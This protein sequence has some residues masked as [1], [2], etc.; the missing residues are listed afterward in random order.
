[1]CWQ[2]VIYEWFRGLSHRREQQFECCCCEFFQLVFLGGEL[3]DGVSLTERQGH[4]WLI[5]VNTFF[6]HIHYIGND[7]YQY[8][9]HCACE[10][11]SVIV[12]FN[13]LMWS[14]L[15]HVPD[16]VAVG[17]KPVYVANTYP[18]AVTPTRPMATAIKLI[19]TTP[20]STANAV[21]LASYSYT[22]QPVANPSVVV[23]S[24]STPAAVKMSTVSSA[25][26][27]AASVGRIPSLISGTWTADWLLDLVLWDSDEHVF[28]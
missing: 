24:H 25:I 20:L 19:Q 28:G 26:T 4:N 27:T 1:M 2:P 10:L 3:T 15:V 13:S 6:L 17:A 22:Y 21:S 12:L 9:L 14:L 11:Y 23:C 8:S 7:T 18:P 5:K 16:T